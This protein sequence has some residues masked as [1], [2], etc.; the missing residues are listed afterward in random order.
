MKIVTSV[1]NNPI[2]I[3]I[4]YHTLKQFMKSD[5]EFI[6]FNDAKGFADYTND[7]DIFIRDKITRL[8]NLL[9]I[10]CIEIPNDHHKTILNASYRTAESMNFILEYQKKNP[11]KYLLID[12]DMFLIDYFNEEEFSKYD[13]AMVVQ[14][15]NELCYI[16]NGI[17][18]FNI[19]NLNTSLMNWHC[20]PTSDTGGQMHKWLIKS[21]YL[22]NNK[23]FHIGHFKSLTW[24]Q[25]NIKFK[26]SKLMDFLIS[27]PRNKDN[28]FFCEI[29]YNKFL[30]YRAGGNWQKKKISD[31]YE[32]SEKLKNALVI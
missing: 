16:W 9:N 1:V 6:V 15:R 29:Y 21:N 10:E 25:S 3:E 24:N 20:T 31:H 12:S 19:K 28:H 23:A 8:C 11:D 4:Q 13:C 14:N 26:N 30:H 17:Y 2:F 32:L 27:D 22:N 7:G 18:Y 5:Y